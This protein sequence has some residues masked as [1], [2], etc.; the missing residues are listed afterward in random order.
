[1]ATTERFMAEL[2]DL[3]PADEAL[4]RLLD[5]MQEQTGDP[6]MSA[7]EEA[8]GRIVASPLH[9]P[10]SLPSFVRSTMDGYALRAADS[11]GASEALPA[12]LQVAGEVL[13]GESPH[14]VIESGLCALV[15]TGGM[16]PEGADAVVMVERTRQSRTGEIEVLRPVAAGENLIQI[17]EDV[18]ADSLLFAAGH[19]LRP[20]DIGGLCALGIT[21]VPLV[22]KPRIA[23]ISTGD[24]VVLPSSVPKPGQVRDVNSYTIAG[25][26][27]Q[28]GGIPDRRGVVA[29]DYGEILKQAR[30]ALESSDA[31]V[32]SAG[33]S[34]SVRDLTARVI[35]A[36]GE[37]G[38]LVHGVNIKPGKPTILAVCDGKA[39]IGLP[40]NPVSAFVSARLFLLPALRKLLGLAP[41][42]RS[43]PD[44]SSGLRARLG[45]NISSAA[46]R[47]DYVPVRL[48][49]G[50]GKTVTAEPVFGKS[51]LIYTLI[52]ADGLVTVP[53]DANGLHRD[54]EVEVTL[55]S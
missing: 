52:H 19:R 20:Q 21:R 11:Y 6:E 15:H 28:A 45:R 13:M 33:S 5:A 23:V 55:F 22:P 26:I 3:T 46:G 12:Y 24:E 18:G 7:V 8:L 37:P 4:E 30:A 9:S 35:G 17:G 25:L 31:L 49:R 1:M 43:V 10:Q 14:L 36:L 34:V 48:E 41:R 53:V 16:V 50:P 2:F 51:N 32:I 44:V 38:V 27:E 54:D 39:V 47:T 29:D 42:G 40:G